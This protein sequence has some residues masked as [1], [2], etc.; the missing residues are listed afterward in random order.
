MSGERDR[1][2]DAA[3]R[4][5]ARMDAGHWTSADEE[6]LQ[7]WLAEDGARSGLLLRTQACWLATGDVLYPPVVVEEPKR[8][9]LGRRHA[10][11]GAVAAV[12]AAVVGRSL[13]FGRGM[14]YATGLGEIRR[15][16]LSDGSVMMINSSTAL[17]VRMEAKARQ[18]NLAEG[19]A[20]F[21]VA[22]D[23]RRPFVVFA[24]RVRAKA[25]GTAFSVRVRNEGVEV[26]VTEG[27]V[28]AWADDDQGARVQVTAGQRVLVKGDSSVR[29]E[30]AATSPVERILAWRE[31]MI[32]LTGITLGDAADEFNRY[33][34]R[35]IIV[36]NPDLA[37][38]RLDGVFRIDD[39]EGFALAVRSS[40]DAT[41]RTNDPSVIRI[42]H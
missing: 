25:V 5:V 11:G 37:A 38:E 7:R 22:K 2:S 14:A 23:A 26:L 34:A 3:A 21:E 4:W 30:P 6:E 29:Y 9:V 28:E 13:L 8:G 19:E 17:N 31:G 10:L 24:G 35:K 40:L 39:P 16:P 15:V 18:V 1:P 33:N 12:F 20:W 36:T 42:E 27:I 32:D 41:V